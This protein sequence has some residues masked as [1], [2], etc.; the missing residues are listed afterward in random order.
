MESAMPSAAHNR[1]RTSRRTALDE[2]EHAHQSVGGTGRG[3]RYATQQ[4]NHAYAVLLSSQFQGCCRDLHSECADHLV[5][6]V[7]PA[8]LHT[9]LRAA[10]TQDR[11]LDRGNPN[12][13]NI[14]SDFGRLGLSFWPAVQAIHPRNAARQALLEELN[15]WRNAIAHQDFDPGRLG[16]ATT[17]QLARV[18]RWRAA[19]DALAVAFD[20]VMRGH[21]LTV[22]GA[23]PW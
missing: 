10:L 1:W 6:A 5:R 20:D 15:I 2:L 14:G 8:T 3:R 17:L 11:K 22:T 12:P 16:G 13:G 21:A 4:I 19:C 9:A 7:I 18:R 23:A